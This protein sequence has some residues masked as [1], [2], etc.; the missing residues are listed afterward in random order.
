MTHLNVEIV[1]FT[2]WNAVTDLTKYHRSLLVSLE[3]PINPICSNCPIITHT[4]NANRFDI[5]I[6]WKAV[7]LEQELY[8]EQLSMERIIDAIIEHDT[9]KIAVTQVVPCL[10]LW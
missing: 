2:R 1:G 6:D 4:Y 8:S 3:F 5:D 9:V 10:F 7:I